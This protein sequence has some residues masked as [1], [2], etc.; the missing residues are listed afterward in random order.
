MEHE[1]RY[2]DICREIDGEQV[3]LFGIQLNADGSRTFVPPA[4]WVDP[5]ELDMDQLE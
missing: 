2:F 3:I 5:G 1:V 4:D